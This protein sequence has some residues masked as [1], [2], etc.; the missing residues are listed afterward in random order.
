MF[1]ACSC[2][3]Q[4]ARDFYNEL[5][6]AGGLDQILSYRACFD[7]RPEL[8]TFFIF[9]ESKV[10]REVMTMDESFAKAPK[11]LQDKLKKNFLI[12][13][14][15]DKG[16]PLSTQD[17]MNADNN[18]SWISDKF[19]LDKSTPARVRFNINWET[20]RY[21]RSVE[22]LNLEGAVIGT[23]P[24]YGRCELIPPT[25]HQHGK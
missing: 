10:I 2:F 24:A 17:T 20:L 7:E 13:R 12:F 19:M 15:Y 21:K 8:Q 1:M 22:V 4:T 11:S 14:G 9:T 18:G 5:Y 6:A 16:V 25:V 3:A 23:V